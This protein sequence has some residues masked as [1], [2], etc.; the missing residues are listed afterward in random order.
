[1]KA[2]VPFLSVILS[3]V[4]F[5]CEKSETT[6]STP[7]TGKWKLFYHF[8]GIGI[9]GPIIYKQADPETPVF[10]DIKSDGKLSYTNTNYT[11][12]SIKDSITVTFIGNNKDRSNFGYSIKGDTLTLSPRG[13]IMCIEGCG[14]RFL[15]VE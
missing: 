12:L 6:R 10:L 1:M 8:H 15:K 7:L 4:F 14:Q 5:S 9:G 2:S 11:A 3:I 13:S